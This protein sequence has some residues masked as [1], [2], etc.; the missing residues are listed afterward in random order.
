MG[1]VEAAIGLLQICRRLQQRDMGPNV[2]GWGGE[3]VAG[4]QPMSTAVHVT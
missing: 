4:S 3:G 2:G 1:R